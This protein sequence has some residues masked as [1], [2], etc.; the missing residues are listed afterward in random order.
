MAT[1][2]EIEKAFMLVLGAGLDFA[3]AKEDIPIRVNS[4][5]DLL[6]DIPGD[7]LIQAAKDIAISGDKFPSVPSIR[8]QAEKVK[9]HN[10]TSAAPNA[11]KQEPSYRAAPVWA[12][13]E[14][15]RLAREI[16]D[17]L[18]LVSM[19]EMTDEQRA[20]YEQAIGAKIGSEEEHQ[21]WNSLYSAA[22]RTT[23]LE[24]VVF[25]SEE[26]LHAWLTRGELCTT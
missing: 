25:N 11:F 3:P 21:Y 14:G 12:Q 1:E 4:W 9:S 15:D 26:T 7:T 10:N 17:L 19:D 2:A 22:Y 18:A 13:L 23:S 6:T 8:K 20:R 24:P 16:G 5:C